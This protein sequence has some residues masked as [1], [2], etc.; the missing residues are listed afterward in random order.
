MFYFTYNNKNVEAINTQQ[1]TAVQKNGKPPIQKKYYTSPKK[2][3][4]MRYDNFVFSSLSDI[5]LEAP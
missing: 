3:V 2:R 5:P 1:N 4:K